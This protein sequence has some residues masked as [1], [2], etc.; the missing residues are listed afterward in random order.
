MRS[1]VDKLNRMASSLEQRIGKI[2]FFLIPRNNFIHILGI[3]IENLF[4]FVFK[5]RKE[6]IENPLVFIC[7]QNFDR[8]DQ[9]KLKIKMGNAANKEA[10]MDQGSSNANTAP[11]S[12]EATEDNHFNM[13]SAFP[14]FNN[15]E[16]SD[17]SSFNASSAV[18]RKASMDEGSFNTNQ[19]TF[20]AKNQAFNEKDSFNASPAAIN[21][22]SLDEI[23]FN[24]NQ[25]TFDAKNQAFN[26][27]DSFNASPAAEVKTSKKQKTLNAKKQN[28]KEQ[29]S[30]NAN[31]PE[32]N[33]EAMGSFN[34]HPDADHQATLEL[35]SSNTSP[36]AKEEASEKQSD[37]IVSQIS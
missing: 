11:N 15:E 31:N 17:Q 7:I 36:A 33:N 8:Q 5:I 27:Q 10:S 26:E 4:Y 2:N 16:T 6:N 9:L 25:A 32:G 29:E 13:S 24:A 22:V 37:S 28:F 23:S 1:N 19:E 34:A 18:K 20:D 21:E 14:S 3:L 30:F 35:G 12:S